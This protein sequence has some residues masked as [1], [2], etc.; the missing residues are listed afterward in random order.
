MSYYQR[1]GG[2]LSR[3]C[4]VCGRPQR[5]PWRVLDNVW[6]CALHPNYIPRATAEKVPLV[7]LPPEK[8]PKGLKPWNPLD[9]WELA[10]S[11]ILELVTRAPPYLTGDITASGPGSYSTSSVF[12]LGGACLYLGRLA[13]ENRRPVIWV[14]QAQA[15]IKRFATQLIAQQ[16]GIGTAVSTNPTNAVTYGAFSLQADEHVVAT[17]GMVYA[18]RA[19]GV[20]QYLSSATAGAAF[21][22]TLQSTGRLTSGFTSSDAG[23]AS[24]LNTGGLAYATN[25]S[26]FTATQYVLVAGMAL[27]AYAALKVAAG[28]VTVGSAAVDGGSVFAQSRAATLTAAIA[29]TRG[30]LAGFADAT[31]TVVSPI[32]PGTLK[33]TFEP[34]PG[35][36]HR[37]QY[38]NGTHT[39]GTM[40]SASA[41]AWAARGLYE[42]EGL[43]SLVTALYDYV[44]GFADNGTYTL[45][46]TADDRVKWAGQAGTFDAKKAPS[47]LLLVRDSSASYATIK[48]PG[49]SFYDLAAAGLLAPISNSRQPASLRA[50]KEELAYPRPRTGGAD[51]TGAGNIWLPPL[52]TCGFSWQPWSTSTTRQQTVLG[53][54]LTGEVYRYGTTFLGRGN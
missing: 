29:E 28:D 45:A 39:T 36:S 31:G 50:L 9:T 4:D 47:T 14:E 54:A 49:S 3:I 16:R 20:A 32:A 34:Y 7:V 1:L 27:W 51:P 22:R 52:G 25:G 8:L 53:A 37:W 18:Y 24:R 40:V 48:R 35:G 17:L 21:M 23:G 2:D 5:P 26:T 6:I 30:F 33:E 15:A 44:I 13:L 12:S 38:T 11:T 42:A 19:T 10:E 43:S 46:S 41:V